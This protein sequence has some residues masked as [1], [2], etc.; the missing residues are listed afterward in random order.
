MTM[1]NEQLA[2]AVKLI[3]ELNAKRTQGSDIPPMIDGI[4]ERGIA[5]LDLEANIP[6]MADIIAQLTDIVRV[7][8][9]ANDSIVASG[10]F[11]HLDKRIRDKV[12]SALALSAPIVKKDV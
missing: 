8:H 2:E 3:A 1:T 12:M 5:R 6:L 9:E 7:Q 11:D 4:S 10:S